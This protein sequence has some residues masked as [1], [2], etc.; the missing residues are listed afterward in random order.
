MRAPHAL[1]AACGYLFSG[2]RSSLTATLVPA[3]SP[4]CEECAGHF[5]L[6]L[7]RRAMEHGYPQ[8]STTSQRP[9][10]TPF[11]RT[12]HATSLMTIAHVLRQIPTPSR[13]TIA[14]VRPCFSDLGTPQARDARLGSVQERS[15]ELLALKQEVV[16]RLRSRRGAAEYH[17]QQGTAATGRETHACLWSHSACR[18][19]R[20][21]V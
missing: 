17:R 19:S 12:T 9:I 6:Q 14:D 11:D 4:S 20:P 15:S 7:R 10:W 5:A 2:S 21:L 3:H 1:V 16:R 18:P 13:A 8:N